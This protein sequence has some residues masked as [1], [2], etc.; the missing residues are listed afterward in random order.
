MVPVEDKSPA[1]LEG[2]K[3]VK[4]ESAALEAFCVVG[5]LFVVKRKAQ[6]SGAAVCYLFY[7][8]WLCVG[9]FYSSAPSYGLRVVMKYLYP[10]LII[11]FASAAVRDC[12]VFLKAALGARWVAIISIAVFFIPFVGRKGDPRRI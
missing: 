7:L 2:S 12:E 1:L 10:L 11:L 9:I 4:I 3:V 5:L 6:W 8:I